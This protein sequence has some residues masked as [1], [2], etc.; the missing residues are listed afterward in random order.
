MHDTITLHKSPTIS[1][2]DYRRYTSDSCVKGSIIRQYYIG[3]NARQGGQG[4][5]HT[6]VYTSMRRDI[7]SPEATIIKSHRMLGAEQL[8]TNK[9]VQLGGKDTKEKRG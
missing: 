3:S 8:Y 9:Q 2:L 4:K 7:M 5:Q 6:L 1:K